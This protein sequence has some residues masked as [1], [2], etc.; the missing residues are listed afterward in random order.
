VSRDGQGPTL[1]QIEADLRVDRSQIDG[2][3]ARWDRNSPRERNRWLRR[4]Q[5]GEQR[6]DASETVLASDPKLVERWQEFP[7]TEQRELLGTIDH[8]RFWPAAWEMRRAA[9][10]VERGS[11]YRR[12]IDGA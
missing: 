3:I 7:V 1:D 12:L 11:D 8:Y 9:K 10:A 5:R 2:A 4:F 6:R